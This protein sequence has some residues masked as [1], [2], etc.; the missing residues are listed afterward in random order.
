MLFPW[1]GLFSLNIYMPIEFD[2]YLNIKKRNGIIVQQFGTNA[3][4]LS[5]FLFIMI[6]KQKKRE[7][8]K[9]VSSLEAICLF[10]S[11]FIVTS[12]EREEKKENGKRANISRGILFSSRNV[13]LK[14]VL[15]NK[16]FLHFFSSLHERID[17]CFFDHGIDN[18][19]PRGNVH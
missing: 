12:R 4:V 7:E 17:H 1:A 19:L 3:T 8:E 16:F 13:V 11:Y 14:R 2:L 18:S 5:S 15:I 10:V 6:I 9:I